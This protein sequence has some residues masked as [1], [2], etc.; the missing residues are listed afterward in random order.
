MALTAGVPMELVRRVTGH[1]TVNVVLKHDF[2][3]KREEFRKALE[4]ALPQALTG[5]SEERFDLDKEV[6]QLG[7]EADSLRHEELAERV[8]ALA[9]AVAA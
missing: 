5:G 9:K 1:S 7:E 2:R 4:T 6:L 8:K 3:P